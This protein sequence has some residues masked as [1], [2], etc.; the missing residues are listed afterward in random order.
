MSSPHPGSLQAQCTFW[1]TP[2]LKFLITAYVR[3]YA[4]QLDL[5]SFLVTSLFRA[6]TTLLRHA[7]Q[8]MW[9]NSGMGEKLAAQPNLD[10]EKPPGKEHSSQERKEGRERS[11]TKRQTANLLCI[12]HYI[13][14]NSHLPPFLLFDLHTEL[15]HFADIQF[16]SHDFT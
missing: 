9:A 13:Q 7:H 1:V 10:L 15:V 6:L 5:V 2:G 16:E 4:S 8:H 12:V 3:R 11:I 14:R